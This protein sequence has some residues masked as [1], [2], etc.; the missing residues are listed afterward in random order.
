[1]LEDPLATFEGQILPSKS[2]MVRVWPFC[3]I[4]QTKAFL[5]VAATCMHSASACLQSQPP[6]ICTNESLGRLCQ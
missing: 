1:M 3:F 2:L 4:R 5:R 6:I